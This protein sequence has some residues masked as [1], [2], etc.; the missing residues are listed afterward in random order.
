MQKLR[1]KVRPAIE[2]LCCCTCLRTYYMF[3]Y[4]C[5]HVCMSIIRVKL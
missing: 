1:D 5:V 4:T 2:L 3:E